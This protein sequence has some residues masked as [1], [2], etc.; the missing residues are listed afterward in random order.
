MDFSTK[1][2]NFHPRLDFIIGFL[3][4]KMLIKQLFTI[5]TI[6]SRFYCLLEFVFKNLVRLFLL[7]THQSDKATVNS[8]NVN[9]S[10]L[11]V[12]MTRH[13]IL[14]VLLNKSAY[15]YKTKLNLSK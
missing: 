8:L 6:T 7:D 12:N 5:K 13:F 10:I 2:T 1:L 3:Y 14:L 9:N 4:S 11:Y 15:S